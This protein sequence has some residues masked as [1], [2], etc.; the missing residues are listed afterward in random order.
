MQ[1]NRLSDIL[2]NNWPVLLKNVHHER[3]REAQV[4]FLIEGDS[5]DRGNP[6][7]N[8]RGHCPKA[9]VT[10]RWSMMSERLVTAALKDIIG[11]IGNAG[12]GLI[13]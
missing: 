10:N 2:Q 3:Q 7:G 4:P 8:G 1:K 6:L 11:I 5:E 13:D 9:E 12:L